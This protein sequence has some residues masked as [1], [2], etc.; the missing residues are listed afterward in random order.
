MVIGHRRIGETVEGGKLVHILPDFLVV[1][2]EDV[3]AVLM[4]MDA[5]HCFGIDVPGNMIPFIDDQDFFPSS[6]GFLGKNGTV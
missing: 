4:H 5:F 2:M 1:G 6:F 3:G